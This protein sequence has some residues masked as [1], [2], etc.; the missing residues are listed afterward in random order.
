MLTRILGE[1][2]KSLVYFAEIAKR[3]ESEYIHQYESVSVKNLT[4]D[5]AGQIWRN[6]EIVAVKY[7][8]L[9][10]AMISEMLSLLPWTALLVATSLTHWR[11]PSA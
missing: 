7:K 11:V 4:R 8:Y 10:Y 9:K 1:A 6:S 3:T 2:P 5:V